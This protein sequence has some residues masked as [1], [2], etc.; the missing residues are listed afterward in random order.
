M[1]LLLYELLTLYNSRRKKLYNWV[2]LNLT[3]FVV[4]AAF[5]ALGGFPLVMLSAMEYLTRLLGRE[6]LASLVSPR[7]ASLFGV[8]VVALLGASSS[9]PSHR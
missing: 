8:L 7:L 4:R 3:P 1:S 6:V 2:S 9:S 5:Y